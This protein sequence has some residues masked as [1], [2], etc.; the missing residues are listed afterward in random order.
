[1]T[2]PEDDGL[3]AEAE[4]QAFTE[5]LGLVIGRLPRPLPEDDTERAR[6]LRDA[7]GPAIDEWATNLPID[8]ELLSRIGATVTHRLDQQAEDWKKGDWPT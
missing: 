8:A 1:M 5:V 4:F 2:S 3:W 7:I 6:T